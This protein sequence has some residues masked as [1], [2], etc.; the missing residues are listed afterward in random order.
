MFGRGYGQDVIED[1]DFS[2]SCSATRTTGCSFIDDLRWTDF[3][4]PARGPERHAHDAHHGHRRSDHH[5]RESRES[6]IIVGYIN[7]I[8][9]IEFGDGTVWSY[10][11]LLQHYIDIAK[12][13]GNDTI[14]GFDLSDFIDGGAGDDRLEGLGGNDIYYFAPGYG[15]DTILDYRRRRAASRSPALPRSDVDLLAH[16]ARPD[17]HGHRA[18]ASGSSSRTSMSATTSSISRS[19]ISSSPTGPSSFTRLQSGGHRPRRD[20]RRRD[21]HRLGLRRDA[22]RPRRRRHAD[23]RRWRRYLQV[24]R[25]LRPGRHRRPPRARSLAATVRAP[26]CRS[27]TSSCSATTSLA[28]QRRV[29][30]GRRRPRDLGPGPHRHAAD[31]QPVPQRR[32]RNR[33]FRVP[34][35]HLPDHL[36]TSRQILQ[37]AG[38]NRGDNII[39]GSATQPNTLDGR[40][41]DDTLIGGNAGRHLCIHAPATTSTG[42]SSSPMRRA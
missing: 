10:T 29:H 4:Y 3:D 19:N 27:T 7:L 21:H 26:S 31:P 22:R 24:R 13:A 36:P 6:A 28:D 42:S 35:R 25:R 41:G 15:S 20:Q 39:T 16:R 9:D 14:Y 32:G 12:T 17:H 11:K 38:G 2:T 5:D 40:Q 30:Q 33:A 8:E 37:I 1:N 34:G 23:R 18:P